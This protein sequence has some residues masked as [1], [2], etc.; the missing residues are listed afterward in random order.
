MPL[1]L[2]QVVI[3]LP[4]LFFVIAWKPFERFNAALALLLVTGTS[5]ISKVTQ[6]SQIQTSWKRPYRFVRLYKVDLNQFLAGFDYTGVAVWW[7]F[8]WKFMQVCE[9]RI[10]DPHL[11]S[12]SVNSNG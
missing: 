10:R 9:L 7:G 4:D 1:P 12:C 6:S 11:I 3:Q 8:V 5:C 2:E